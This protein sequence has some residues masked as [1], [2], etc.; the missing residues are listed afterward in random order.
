[1]TVFTLW[2]LLSAAAPA[3][4]AALR[5]RVET[6][7]AAVQQD[8]ENLHL[9]A[10]YRELII[11]AADFDRSI[12]IFE[13]LAA[14]RDSGPNVHIS[15]ALAYV[16]KAPAVGDM[17]RLSLG[18]EAMAEATR[19]IERRPSALAYYIR[20]RINL[21]FNNLIFHRIPT[22]IEDLQ[23]ALALVTPEIPA[24]FVAHV[25]AAI[26]DGYWR[27]DQRDKARE[28]WTTGARRCQGDPT[29][30]PRLA[31]DDRVVAGAVSDSLDAR[32][33]IDTSLRGVWP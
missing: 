22:G 25:Y 2:L 11:E 31:S 5:T 29:L 21:F 7:E 4:D 15:L 18:R 1:M 12:R 19:A 27:L 3:S 8:P 30:A 23:R 33:R 17:R 28:V 14:R 10:D 16:D 13:K 9:A 32:N 6:L 24:P 26:G 20:G